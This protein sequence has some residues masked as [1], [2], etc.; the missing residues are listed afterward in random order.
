MMTVAIMA[1]GVSS[2]HAEALTGLTSTCPYCDTASGGARVINLIRAMGGT[3]QGGDGWYT[4]TD[5]TGYIPAGGSWATQAQ[6]DLQ[7][8]EQ[9]VGT[10]SVLGGEVEGAGV[11]GGG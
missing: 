9:G 6:S 11:A 4:P 3:P 8:V 2:A 1:E 10:D 5:V 7:T